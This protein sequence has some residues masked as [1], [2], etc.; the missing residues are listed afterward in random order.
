[1]LQDGYTLMHEHM[2]IDLSKAKKNLDCRVDCVDE[3]T[4]EMKKL[5]LKGVRNIVEVTNRGMGR[6]VAKVQEISE[7]SNIN[8][9]CST[10]FYK[11]PFLPEYV[12]TSSIEELSDLLISDIQKG[13]D[14]TNIRAKML[15]EIGTSKSEMTSLEKKVFESVIQAHKKTGVPISTHTTL[16]TFAKEQ[17]KFLKEHGVNLSKV[18]IGHIDLSDNIRYIVDILEKG[19]YV[20]FDT[21]GKNNYLP[22]LNRAKLL[23]KLQDLNML[24]KVFLSLDISRKSN[25]EFMGGIGYSYLFDKFL[26]LLKE[27][28]ITDESIQKMLYE[29]P[30]KFF[31]EL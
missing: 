14:G 1:M 24:D 8:F 12:Y 4:Q 16:G 15:A 7:N 18:I 19:V 13:M 31:N 23:K 11:Q 10:G 3:M 27:E 6:N 28:G 29:N 17:V 26:P 5:Y 20:A 2:F 25:M 22:D 9:I 21:I 30:R